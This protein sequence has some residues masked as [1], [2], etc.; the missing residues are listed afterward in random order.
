MA[1]RM[2]AHGAPGTGLPAVAAFVLALRRTVERVT[3]AR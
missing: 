2:G 1:T 3:A